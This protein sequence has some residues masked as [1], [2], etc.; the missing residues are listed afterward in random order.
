MSQAQPTFADNVLSFYKQISI[1]VPLPKGVEILNPY[2]EKTAF[3]LCSSFYRK[4]YDDHVPR[5]I[6][7][8]INPGRFGGGITGVPFTDPIKLELLCGIQNSMIKKAE[9]SADF[10][11]RMIDAYGGVQKF[12]GKF[13]INSASPLGFT[14]NDKNLNY[15]DTPD[16]IKAL[17]GFITKSLKQ[18]VSFGLH[19]NVAFCLGEGEN[20]KF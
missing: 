4:Y 16:L 11:Y 8:G 12:Y 5:H 17:T 18:Q 7:I 2:Q 15:Y 6:I 1:D 19:T 10:I 14:L 3:E 9:L 13:Y 20:Y